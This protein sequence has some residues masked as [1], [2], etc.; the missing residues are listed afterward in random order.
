[1]AA[2]EAHDLRLLRPSLSMTTGQRYCR[3]KDRQ[4]AYSAKSA[5]ELDLN[6]A[7]FV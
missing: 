6:L 2:F 1:L 7:E 5:D 4:S 3:S